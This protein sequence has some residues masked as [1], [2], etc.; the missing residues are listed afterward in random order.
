MEREIFL[1]FCRLDPE[2]GGGVGVGAPEGGPL[3]LGLPL[4]GPARLDLLSAERALGGPRFSPALGGISATQAACRK[5]DL[6][7]PVVEAGPLTPWLP[8]SLS[9]LLSEDVTLPGIFFLLMISL[10]AP[11][12]AVVFVALLVE[13]FT[14]PSLFWSNLLGLTGSFLIVVELECPEY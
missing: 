3:G 10:R 1:D 8:C 12:A 13:R 9:E 4:A 2:L 5:T 11:D 14:L 6:L 7:P